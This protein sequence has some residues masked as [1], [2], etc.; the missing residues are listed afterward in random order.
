M[1]FHVGMNMKTKI[2]ICGITNLDDALHAIDCGADAIGFIF[3][4]KSS[5]Y[6]SLT[7]AKTIIKQLPPFINIVGLC[8][9]ADKEY[10]KQVIAIGVNII[11]F[12]GDEDPIFC[13]QFNFPYIKA[14]HSHN[15]QSIIDAKD[16]YTDA[17]AILIDTKSDSYGGTGKSFDW[18]II[19]RNIESKLIIAGG[20]DAKNIKDLLTTHSPVAVDVCSGLERQKGIKDHTKIKEFCQIVKGLYLS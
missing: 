20:L 5:R 11:Q 18:S 4:A 10:V 6:I 15:R 3:Y 12:H 7:H 17:K 13:Q 9:N 14:I 2:K 16:N 1:I 8:V 19:P